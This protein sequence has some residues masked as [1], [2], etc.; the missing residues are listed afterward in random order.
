MFRPIRDIIIPIVALLAL[1]AGGVVLR[2]RD[3]P[4]AVKTVTAPHDG[5]SLNVRQ[6]GKALRVLWDPAVESILNATHG[7]LHITD[8]NHKTKLNL[9][10]ALLQAGKLN[11]WPESSHLAFQLDVFN[12][13]RKLSGSLEIGDETTAAS[14]ESPS[15]SEPEPL[16]A[17]SPARVPAA[18]PVKAAKA[19]KAK[20]KKAPRIT[21][22]SAD[23]TIESAPSVP[24]HT[25]PPPLPVSLPAGEKPVLARPEPPPVHRASRSAVAATTRPVAESRLRRVAGRVPLVRRLRKFSEPVKPPY[26][27]RQVMPTITAQDRRSLAMPLDMDVMVEVDRW[28]K[29]SAVAPLPGPAGNTSAF[30]AAAVSAARSWRFAP[31]RMGE[32]SVPGKVILHFT[33]QPSDQ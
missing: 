21:L 29:V 13:E 33:F 8:G 28:G 31:A 32:E 9:N 18:S 14:A 7:E 30:A 3:T 5:L 23:R 10:R 27:V 11:Y 6:E 19:S 12:G 4:G 1:A 16:P 20:P 25:L 26:P 22:A 15:A 17:V 2:H 24:P